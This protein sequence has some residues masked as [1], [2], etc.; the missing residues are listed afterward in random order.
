MPFVLIGRGLT[1]ELSGG[2][3]LFGNL[4]FSFGPGLTGLV[5]PNGIGK[6]CLARLLAGDLEPTSG[7]VQRSL[8][9][10]LLPQREVPPAVTVREL[11]GADYA[12]PWLGER[13]LAGV[14]RDALCT[15]LSGGQW[16][17]ARLARII[18]DSFLILDEPTNDLDGDGRVAVADFLRSQSSGV[19]LISHDRECLELCEEIVELSNRGLA[20]YGCGWSAYVIERER[21]RARLSGALEVAKRERDTAVAGRTE[22][23]VKRERRD[24]QARQKARRG[25]VPKMVLSA[26]KRQ[27]EHTTGARAR[28]TLEK[29]EIAIRAAH[30]ALANLKIDPVMYAHVAGQALPAQKLVAQASAFNVRFRSWIY[31]VDLDFA[32]RGNVRVAI[33]G[34]NGSGK[35]TLLRALRG[36]RLDTR[37]ELLRGDLTALYI[38][39]RC[40]LLDEEGSVLRNVAA[41]STGTESE[42]RSA[43]AR[44]LFTGNEVLQPVKA[45]SGGERG[46][47]PR[48]RRLSL[49][50]E[51]RS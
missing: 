40:S 30:G 50:L 24:R 46:C 26:R 38:D 20:R 34:T 29:A 16:M 9:V 51:H 49:P 44:F 31:A 39:Q 37:G 6:T 14:R 2:R 11:L 47:A 5:G 17:R 25:G 48:S 42:I 27:A 33:Q 22:Q 36:E 32:W 4:S 41:S 1:Y 15:A 3:R 43:L 28:T 7:L 23:A 8:P 21:E 35:T 19:L 45:L 10:K 12:Y 13:L 18:D